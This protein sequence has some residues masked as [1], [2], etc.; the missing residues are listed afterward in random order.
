MDRLPPKVP[1]YDRATQH[2]TPEMPRDYGE[3]AYDRITAEDIRYIVD[4][5]LDRMNNYIESVAMTDQLTW[6]NVMAPLDNITDQS[7]LAYGRALMLAEVHP[8]E[9][10]RDEAAAQ[11]SRLLQEVTAM[12]YRTDI[13]EKIKTYAKTKEGK[14]LVGER[15]RAVEANMY[16][17]ERMGHDLPAEKQAR[18][19][20]LEGLLIEKSVR[21]EHNMSADTTTLQLTTDEL[22]G[23]S[24]QFI[25]SLE[26]ADDG[27][28][29][30]TM[31][32]P[33]VEPIL[34][35]A[36]NRDVR[37]KLSHAFHSMGGEENHEILR[38]T[39]Q[40]RRE[41]AQLLGFPSWAHYAMDTM[42]VQ[43]PEKL[44]KF[45]NSLY[46]PLMKHALPQLDEMTTMLYEDGHEGPL[47]IYDREYYI[48]RLQEAR[49]GVDHEKI[50]EYFPV[51]N[52]IDGLHDLTGGVFSV[53]YTKLENEPVWHEDVMVYEV[54]EQE[55]GE[56]IGKFYLDLFS[57]PGKY[58]HA[59]TVPM[60]YARNMPDGTNRP[61]VGAIIANY[62]RDFLNM[63]EIITHAHEHGHLNALLFGRTEVMDFAGFNVEHDF[64]EAISQMF[65]NWMKH[66]EILQEL[67][68]S[69]DGQPIDPAIFDGLVQ[70]QQIHD[71]FEYLRRMH[72]G[73]IDLTLHGG[74]EIEDIA[75]VNRN[76]STISLF[77]Q[78]E[79]TFLPA[80]FSHIMNG[81]EGGYH[82]YAWSK[83][84]SDD[85]F[86]LFEEGGLKNPAIGMHY[87]RQIA[88]KGGTESAAT[89]ERK[90]LGRKYNKKA[91]LRR[92]GIVARRSSEVDENA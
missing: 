67:A 58:T 20:E 44:V 46:N 72:L 8:D 49:H 71:L 24:E 43:T 69:P 83:V 32:Y 34:T 14:Q 11:Q 28:R 85:H 86:S 60:Q 65:E 84:R 77:L 81:Y 12:Y 42:M 27:T 35:H 68:V 89:M 78:E 45:Y 50:A 91:F 26:R 87:R 10:V 53:T 56:L 15:G 52:F 47:M 33:H 39:L 82:N 5:A 75:A 80:K 6:E 61:A 90:Y 55:T 92:L 63:E 29:I 51:Q 16:M 59:M 7:N 30:V 54:H 73:D 40:L 3:F 41:Y 64:S 36:H 18:L 88:N 66:S 74:E 2:D 37:R 70:S 23:L 48:A 13:S 9:A 4:D 17:F 21:Y 62:S 76:S 19:L 22:D 57:R 25:D 38:E 1:P 31:K 79:G